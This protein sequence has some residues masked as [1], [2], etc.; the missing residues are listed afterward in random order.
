M[1]KDNG[2]T[3]SF[4]SFVFIHAKLVDRLLREQSPEGLALA[5]IPSGI[6]FVGGLADLNQ[7]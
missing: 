2:L 5:G 4:A 7:G 1:K 3:I 6:G